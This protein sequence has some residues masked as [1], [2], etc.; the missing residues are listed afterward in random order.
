VSNRLSSLFLIAR[1]FWSRRFCPRPELRN[2]LDGSFFAHL[3]DPNQIV[4]RFANKCG[5]FWILMGLDSVTLLDSRGRVALE[6]GNTSRAGVKHRDALVDQLESVPVSGHNEN[7]KTLR[8]PG[9]RER[10]EDVV[11]FEVFLLQ[12]DN[13]HGVQGLLK[14]GNLT[15]E[16]R[17]SLPPG[18]F[19]F[20]INPGSK[21]KS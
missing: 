16:L 6:F 21:R 15:D 13:P 2:P 5:N 17:R 1:S 18:S 11:G 20:G 3:V 8:R 9:R 12:S 14:K 19:V 7:V 4:A 10:G